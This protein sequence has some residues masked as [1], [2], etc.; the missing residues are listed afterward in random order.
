M[1]AKEG[2]TP[3][4]PDIKLG[5]NLSVVVTIGSFAHLQE[6]AAIL[7]GIDKDSKQVLLLGLL[8]RQHVVGAQGNSRLGVTEC[9]EGTSH[10]HYLENILGANLVDNVLH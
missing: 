4:P 8:W 6:M 2:L 9:K 5:T 1:L 7:C 3:S 10:G